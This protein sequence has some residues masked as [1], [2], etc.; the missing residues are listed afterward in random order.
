V[1]DHPNA[2]HIWLAFVDLGNGAPVQIVFGGQRKVSE[3]DLV[4]VAPP[5]SRLSPEAKKM[6]R[7]R[8]RGESSHG[9][10][11]SLAE[12]GW[13]PESDEEVALLRDVTPGE[14]LDDVTAADDW[15]SLVINVPST[16]D[17]PVIDDS[18]TT[19]VQ[20]ADSG[21]QPAAR[22]DPQRSVAAH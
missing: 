12:L 3:D 4:P 7:R 20:V 5:G 10:L 1:R 13:A 14:S 16:S 21:V 17:S 15:K 9:M 22:P 2:E 6:R 8:Y 11:C 19:I 18:G